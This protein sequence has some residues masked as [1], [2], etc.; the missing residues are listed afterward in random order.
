M[1]RQLPKEEDIVWKDAEVTRSKKP[2]DRSSTA[3]TS[4]LREE[5]IAWHAPAQQQ[6]SPPAQQ[7][8]SF[9]QVFDPQTPVQQAALNYIVEPMAEIARSYYGGAERLMQKG[10]AIFDFSSKLAALSDEDS[11]VA[12]GLK[13][14]GDYFYD[15]KEEAQMQASGIP[16]TE[17]HPAAKIALGVVAQAPQIYAEYLLAGKALSAIPATHAAKAAAL[18]KD[19][20]RMFQNLSLVERSALLGA[21]DAYD[22]ENPVESSLLGAGTSAA[23]AGAI[24]ASPYV[25]GSA[26]SLA[27][28]VGEKVAIGYTRMV[29]GLNDKMAKHVLA[30]ALRGD[31]VYDFSI[32]KN[33]APSRE[34]LN[35]I[36]KNQERDILNEKT[37]LLRDAGEKGRVETSF[38]QD[39]I[40]AS[41]EKLVAQKN[42][43]IE[44]TKVKWDARLEEKTQAASNAA[45]ET[46]EALSEKAQGITKTALNSIKT[47]EASNSAL[48]HN[49]YNQAYNGPAGSLAVPANVGQGVAVKLDSLFKRYGTF[50]FRQEDMQYSG[51]EQSTFKGIISEV[52]R[53]LALFKTYLKEG[54]L[55]LSNIKILHDNFDNIAGRMA[56][57]AASTG[58][59]IGDFARKAAE[60]LDPKYYA[61]AGSA[62]ESAAIKY[63]VQKRVLEGVKGVFFSDKEGAVS[64]NIKKIAGALKQNNKQELDAF[65]KLSDEFDTLLGPKNKM[66]LF[67][68]CVRMIKEQKIAEGLVKKT[69]EQITRQMK[70]NMNKVKSSAAESI[71]RAQKLS[72]KTK[73]FTGVDIRR[74][75]FEAGQGIKKN[76]QNQLDQLT[77]TKEQFQ[78]AEQARSFYA[79]MNVA[80]GTPAGAAQRV[81]GYGGIGAIAAGQ[82]T[83]GGMAL[84]LS[85][86][87][88]PRVATNISLKILKGTKAI[89]K[90]V[91]KLI[92][93]NLSEKA[94]QELLAG[95]LRPKL[96]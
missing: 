12:Q 31:R 4:L 69:R 26:A 49:A 65:K 3:S 47:I 77:K 36:L 28:T 29:T 43:I 10:H 38:A 30:R 80:G 18:G 81:A 82:P 67:D 19:A 39:K 93:P 94:A 52:N 63:G 42:A 72:D 71:G 33:K 60:I 88:S 55:N 50:G 92:V 59:Q 20:P 23:I 58:R 46:I 9:Q 45:A 91:Q 95:L 1:N 53:N 2:L 11:I 74:E 15:L 44:K 25:L 87:L 84:G 57:S 7:E 35:E 75:L 73:L 32:F 40:K 14:I 21:L 86:I 5:D 13:Q 56:P 76:I 70:V 61:P 85:G 90:A 22:Q 79:R 89:D 16:P 83:I 34:G 64:L 24:A 96:R 8:A 62:M 78:A 48:V 66:R 37:R 17:M 6:V 41:L 54:K 68:Q 51:F 27:K